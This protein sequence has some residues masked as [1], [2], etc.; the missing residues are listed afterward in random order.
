MLDSG[1]GIDFQQQ[2]PTDAAIITAQTR[3]VDAMQ[4][5]LIL[6]GLPSA[7]SRERY[8]GRTF[9]NLHEQ[10]RS[11]DY[12]LKDQYLTYRRPGYMN[13]VPGALSKSVGY[14]D[15]SARPEIPDF[16]AAASRLPQ[17]V[18][19]ISAVDWPAEVNKRI[20]AIGL[21]SSPSGQPTLLSAQPSASVPPAQPD[22]PPPA[23][24]QSK[25]G[26][27]KNRNHSRFIGNQAIAASSTYPA[28][29][30]TDILFANYVDYLDKRALLDTSSAN[31]SLNSTMG[32]TPS[33]RLKT[34]KLVRDSTKRSGFGVRAKQKP[35]SPVFQSHTAEPNKQCE[36]TGDAVETRGPN[37]SKSGHSLSLRTML[38]STIAA[39]KKDKQRVDS[40]TQWDQ[41]SIHEL[42]RDAADEQ[43]MSP[44]LDSIESFSESYQFA[45]RHKPPLGPLR[46]VEAHTPAL[47][48]ELNINIGDLLFVIGEFADGWVLAIN[49]SRHSEC[50][51]VPRRCLFFPTAPFMTA[52]AIAAST[53]PSSNQN[54]TQY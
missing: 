49:S 1:T 29:E 13:N 54:V 18:D 20:S 12:A 4:A 39:P 2:R 21:D 7:R 14:V 46:V 8:V 31:P 6:G 35:M 50:G 17:T 40:E 34:R 37:Q 36:Q 44:L 52:E 42:E 43:N 25:A 38:R 5:H 41:P 16:S 10:D 28:E 47:P 15:T 9:P 30:P 48:D 19:Q 51:M 3:E 45:L 22:K 11:A 27:G 32:L 26:L 23:F 33:V 53:R 24:I